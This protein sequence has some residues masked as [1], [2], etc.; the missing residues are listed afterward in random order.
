MSVSQAV[1]REEDT[2]TGS[3]AMASLGLALRFAM[4]EM[5]SGLAEFRVFIACIA[6][7]VSVITGVGALAEA[8]LN[9]FGAQGRQLLGGDI[10]LSRVH[11]RASPPER[12]IMEKYGRVSEL[13][14]MRSMARLPSGDDQALV[15]IKAVD[16]VYPMLGGLLLEGEKDADAALRDKPG[17][18]IARTLINRLGLKTGDDIRIGG[19]EMPITGVIADEPD[20]VSARMPFGPRV[21]V[22]HDTLEK[23]G[24]V[25]PGSL[26]SWHY[27]IA[28]DGGDEASPQAIETLQATIKNDLEESGFIVLDRRDP[29]PTLTRLLDRLRQFLTLLGLAA[30]LIGGVGVA[31]SVQTFIDRRR[32]VI[33]T[34]KSVGASNRMVLAIYLIQVM[35]IALIGTVAGVA[36]G[37]AVP[38][39]LGAVY[40]S[41][42]PIE[43]GTSFSWSNVA[44]GLAYGLLVTLLFALWPL[45]QAERVR[46]AA[47]FR[48]E[49]GNGDRWPSIA[50]M[51]CLVV[52]GATLAGFAAWATGAPALAVGFVVG[53]LAILAVFWLIGFGVTWLAGR[54]PRPRRPELALAMTGLAAP[55]GLA[56]SVVLSLGAGLSLLVAI[57]LVDA[58]LINELRGRMPQSSP[59]YFALDIPKGDREAFE[60]E[61]RS[62]SPDASIEIAPMLR[63]RIVELNGVAAEKAK[64]APE[65]KWALNGDRGVTYTDTLP[66]GSKLVAGTWWAAGDTGPPQVSFAADLAKEMN[67][68]VGDTVTVNILGRNI[69]ARITSLREIEWESLAIN[70]VMVFSPGTLKDAPHNLLATVRFA[71]STPEDLRA[72]AAR[73]IGKSLPSVTFINVKDALETFA[74]VFGKVMIAVR[75]AAAITL[76]AGAL[77][78]AGALATAQRRRVLQAVVLKCIGATRRKLLLAHFAEYGLLALVTAVIA[79]LV[80][81]IAAVM[82]TTYVLDTEFVFSWLAVIGSIGVSVMLILVFGAFG[83]WRVLGAK[84]LP[85]LRG[86]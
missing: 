24:L 25:Q 73:A 85:V 4:R 15:E 54:I 82:V 77:V 36:I 14:T 78:L 42:L 56:R 48:D 53:M 28:A 49:V 22:S 2:R 62:V 47:L 8:L 32:K 45:G 79:L 83:T 30:L 1:D 10:M 9:G 46:P 7:G 71:G 69:T 43:I 38:P 41:V 37:S 13:A 39:I 81:S 40:G 29:N 6:L 76:L 58:S 57:A 44:S 51:I 50:I 11:Q 5:R 55:G 19:L 63:G 12:A 75:V 64:I 34:Y 18:I 17:A 31:N 33:A 16:S 52:I 61:I 65:A 84:P 66:K 80:G 68:A 86:L 3:G 26:I 20:K 21:M 23:T 72:Q 59:D 35:F 67:L 74:G 70:F 60:R 27:A